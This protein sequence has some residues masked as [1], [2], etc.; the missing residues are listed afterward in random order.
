[1]KYL[2]FYENGIYLVFGITKDEKI[3]LLHFSGAEFDESLLCRPKDG[4]RPEDA[5]KREQFIKEAFQLVQVNLSGYDRPYEKHGNKYIATSPG[6]LYHYAGMQDT[7][8]EIGR[9]LVI[10]QEDLEVTMTRVETTLQFYRGTKVVRCRNKITNVGIETQ[11]LEYISSFSYTGI[12]K[13]G[14]KSTDE[15]MR[16][17]IPYNGWQKEVSWKEITFDDAG[18]AQTQPGVCQRTSQVLE[19]T[20]TG[21][22]S[23]KK[24]LPMGYIENCEAH[25]SLFWQI[26][27]N[28]SWHYEI[29]DVH[30][31]FYVSVSGPTE[32]QSHW[33]K[34]LKPGESFE[35]VPVAVGVETDSFDAAM[36]ELTKYRRLLRR[37]NQDNEKL[38]VIFNDYMNCLYGNPTSENE[39]PLIEA[40]AKCGCEYYVIDAG[41]YAPGEWWDGVGEWKECRERFPGG[42][43]EVTDLIRSKGMI[44]GVWL[45]LEVMG[46]RCPMVRKL[47]DDWFFVRHGKRVYDRSRYQLDFRN[48][49]VREYADSIIERVVKEYGVGYIKMDYNI[50]PGI[51]TELAAESPGQGL[52]EHERAY[53]DWLDCIFEKYPELVIENCSSGGL[54]MDYALLSRC[55]IQSM[56]DQEDYRN[57][58]TIAAN[59]A[60]GA[61]MEQA[62]VWSYPMKDGDRE[63]V[64]Y[65]MVNAMLLRIHQSGHL[66]DLSEEHRELVREG[67]LCYK[68]IRKE[69]SGGLPFWPLDLAGNLDTWL[70]FG[71]RTGKS[72]YLAV[73]K[74]NA[75]KEE[76]EIPLTKCEICW[77]QKDL[78]AECIYPRKELPEFELVHHGKVLRV[79]F[80]KPVMARIFRIYGEER[81]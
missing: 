30:N 46:T 26:E 35:T 50:E 47:P 11:T 70:A 78:R 7:R 29:G 37:K 65:N 25:T 5:Q 31:H 58:A 36:G 62:A 14:K 34:E 48:P 24:Y 53:L 28:G 45:E 19:V 27:H 54:R 80:E 13:E 38:P 66:A 76:M 55:S 21:N 44:P 51:G 41:W 43:R 39:L 15:K 42:I 6:Y 2:R 20:N 61:A 23:T 10:T 72:A 68:K 9:C 77:E 79:R 60:T 74:R 1:M 69:I 75:Q 17:R 73:W 33:Y 22:W 57:L 67:I 16:I 71:V 3:K 63:E 52:L 64:I 56:S 8:N 12:E 32:T 18:M 59:A 49:C 81:Y 4:C 40:A